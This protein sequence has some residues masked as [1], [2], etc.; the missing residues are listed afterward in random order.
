MNELLTGILV[1]V[2]LCLASVGVGYWLVLKSFK[3]GAKMVDR[4]HHDA[5]PFEEDNIEPLQSHLDGS[6]E[7]EDY[8][9]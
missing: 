5:D 6:Y 8:G 3:G 7:G 1:G 9:D 4:I 2:G